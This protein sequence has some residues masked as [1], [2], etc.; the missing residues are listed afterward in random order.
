[1]ASKI[2]DGPYI[3]GKFI[4]AFIEYGMEISFYFRV[5]WVCLDLASD[6]R[7]FFFFPWLYSPA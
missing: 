7:N 3:H 2:A 4:I 5:G 1:M 6:L